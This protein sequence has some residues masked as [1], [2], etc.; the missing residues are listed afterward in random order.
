M[1]I[2]PGR[3]ALTRRLLDRFERV[4]AVEIDP[5]LVEYLGATFRDEPKLQVVFCDVLKTDLSQWGPAG[6]VGNLPYYITSPIV[7]QVLT[8]GPLL[9]SAV[10]LV[11]KE[12]ADRIAARPGSRDYGYLSVQCQ[13]FAE[14]ERLFTVPPGAFAPPPKVDSAVFRMRPRQEPLL[15]DPRGFLKFAS[16]CFRQKR[17]TLRNNLASA[18]PQTLMDSL[19]EAGKR[20]EQLS[21]PELIAIYQSLREASLGRPG[22]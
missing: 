9:T 20:A 19:P 15:E 2:G 17:K 22:G 11:Q 7:E 10:F 12:V 13:V 8:M 5:V 16:L 18:Y 3:G 4:V 1:E 21:V 14:V 6:V